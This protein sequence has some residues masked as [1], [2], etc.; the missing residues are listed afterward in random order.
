MKLL[1]DKN[2]VWLT[3]TCNEGKTERNGCPG[4]IDSHCMK[5]FECSVVGAV[6]TIADAEVRKQTNKTQTENVHKED[7]N[8]AI[9]IKKNFVI[10]ALI[11]HN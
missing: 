5:E 8:E 4:A 9:T 3:L 1:H 11:T 10:V 7:T 2:V 6:S